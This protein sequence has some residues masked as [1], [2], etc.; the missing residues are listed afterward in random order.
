[1]PR[2]ALEHLT[3]S[4]DGQRATGALYEALEEIVVDTTMRMPAMCR[5]NLNDDLSLSLISSSTFDIGKQLKVI[6][7][8]D[9]TGAVIFNGEI[10]ALEP[11]FEG[12]GRALLVV[13]AYDKSHR[14]HRGKHSRTFLKQT[15]ENIIQR[16]ASEA[17][18]SLNMTS[19]GVT[20]EFMLQNNQTNMEW[21]LMRAE[22]LGYQVFVDLGEKLH[23]VPADT[24]RGL[25]PELEWGDN[26]ITFRPR[27]TTSHQVDRAVVYSWDQLAKKE[28]KGEATPDNIDTPAGIG[29]NGAALAQGSF[30]SAKSV[31]VAEPVQDANAA[32]KRAEGVARSRQGEFAYAEGECYG[33]DQ[34][35][36][37]GKVN[38]KITADA[39]TRYSGEYKLTSVRHLYRVS[40]GQWTT[41][42]GISGRRPDSLS[43]LLAGNGPG[44]SLHTGSI[45]G[46][47]PALVSNFKDPENLGR[48]KVTYPWLWN[49]ANSTPIESDW[50]RIATPSAGAQRGFFY[51]PEVDDEVL[52]AFEHGDPNR[53]YIVGSLWNR[54]DKPPMP[55]NQI[56]DGSKI[57][58]R[59]IQSRTGH[60][61]LLDD[62]S[63]SEQIVIRDKSQK[64]EIVIDTKNNSILITA[65]KDINIEAGGNINLKAKGGVNIES[66]ADTTIKSKAAF[67]AEAQA[68]AELKGAN[69]VAEAKANMELKS[70][71]QAELKS[72]MVKVTGSAMVEVKGGIIKLN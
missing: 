69:F 7:G 16:M 1:M 39:I 13:Y 71:A 32:K 68:V 25:V 22:Q 43:G 65:D 49:L 30:G 40:T 72:T 5:I 60:I 24:T 21:I 12:N 23:F 20:H 27:L 67:K 57:T 64:N 34:L 14:L 55:T 45:Q 66:T 53:P 36:V 28:I 46:V 11:D 41:Q 29:K 10:T 47:V 58:H 51:T 56:N 48:V 54:K 50:V 19:T 31:V 17:G 35:V 70:N 15:D 6:S 44:D 37:G 62:T 3:F 38:I 33:N 2:T 63:G 18:L 4:V 42:F 9:G 52:V 8:E 61:I 59:L 26:L